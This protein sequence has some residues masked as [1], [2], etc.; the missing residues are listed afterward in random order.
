MPAAGGNEADAGRRISRGQHILQAEECSSYQIVLKLVGRRAATD[1]VGDRISKVLDQGGEAQVPGRCAPFCAPAVC[2]GADV[3]HLLLV[4]GHID[5]RRAELTER[6][7][8]FQNRLCVPALQGRNQLKGEQG[9][10]RFGEDV[11]YTHGSVSHTLDTWGKLIGSH[12]LSLCVE[13]EL[14]PRGL[15]DGKVRKVLATEEQATDRGGGI[16][17][18]TLRQVH[19]DPRRHIQEREQR[20]LLAVVAPDRVA[21]GGANPRW[22]GPS[23]LRLQQRFGQSNE[24]LG[25]AVGQ[26]AQESAHELP[27]PPVR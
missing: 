2:R 13:L 19:P 25:E 26:E 11:G 6:T 23:P 8:R 27:L 3:D 20:R 22:E 18:P 1:E 9:L 16:H 4:V 17:R 7:Y 14:E 10:L 15:A 21:R 5:I 24:H 12:T